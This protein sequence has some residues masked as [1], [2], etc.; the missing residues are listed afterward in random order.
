MRWWCLLA[1]L[2]CR[3][4]ESPPELRV[5]VEVP[6]TPSTD[7][8]LL[9]VIDDSGN[10]AHLQQSLDEGLPGLFDRLGTL[11]LHVGVVT[12][13]LGTSTSSGDI[14]PDIGAVG[15]GGCSGVGNGGN[16]RVGDALVDGVFLSDVGLPDGTRQ[17][18]YDGELAQAVGQMVRVGSTGCG[19]EQPLAAMRTALEANPANAGFVRPDAMLAVIL[20]T[21]EDDCSARDAAL[22]GPAT[23]DNPQQSFRCTRF[24]V[25][26][27]QGGNTSDEMTQPGRKGGCGPSLDAPLLDDP[28]VFHDFLVALKGDP[29]RV[30]VG[31]IVGDLEPFEVVLRAPTSGGTPLPALE[32][33]C[34]FAG[35]GASGEQSADPAVRLS[36]FADQFG[37]RGVTTSVCQSDLVGPLDE[38]AARVNF[39]LGSPCI[40]EPIEL[41]GCVVEDVVGETAT[42]IPPCPSPTCWSIAAD[43]TCP[44]D[45]ALEITRDTPP[46]PATITRLRCE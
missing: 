2:G 12:S 7:L 20:L 10:T 46:D 19:F 11:D 5:I 13:D 24:G 9:F 14:A 1:C 23:A 17:R 15:T 32:R 36:A 43:A 34:T 18:N 45:L 28:T 16:L 38:I 44:L 33:S 6:A 22:F 40:T 26:C 30:V 31:G 41:A 25:T 27:L 4:G 35:P 42:E 39:T 3:G 21:D 29:R 8:D 37:D